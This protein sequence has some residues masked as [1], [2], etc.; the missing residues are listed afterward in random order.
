VIGVVLLAVLDL[1]SYR[2]RLEQI[3]ALLARGDGGRA[4]AAAKSL[5]GETIRWEGED[6][7]AD[8]WALSPIARGEPHRTRLRNL[9]QSL[10]AAREG[11]PEGAPPPDRALLEELR[12]AQ[13]ARDLAAGGEVRG[14]PAPEI[15]LLAQLRGW[16]R[17]AVRWIGER[18]TDLLHWLERFL[19]ERRGPDGEA[20]QITAIVLV[21]VG[22]ILA[23]VLALALG[24]ARRGPPLPVAPGPARRAKDEDPL[25]R[26][27][28]G[29]EERALE[30]AQ[31]GRAREAIRAWYHA[32]LVRCYGAGLLQYR[33]GRTNWEYLRALS[34]QISWRPQFED[35]T[36][37]FDVE[38]YG[39][40]ESTPQAL[41]DFAGTARVILR[42]LGRR[43]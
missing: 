1:A 43:A 23:I 30:L 24:A 25:S 37:R 33:R 5:L 31:A 40:A 11:A 15:S 36:R 22:V 4:A 19:P 2:A 7:S 8:A 9:L 41:S 42:D 32:L 34:P 10:G 17:S 20:G 3:D 16:A 13:A 14:I 28:A 26:T 39:H 35:L 29:W 6:L 38:W 21:A 12:R 18:L 27:A